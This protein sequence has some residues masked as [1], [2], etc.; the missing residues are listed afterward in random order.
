MSGKHYTILS[1]VR[2]EYSVV[3]L[4]RNKAKNG[5]RN[6]DHSF[7]T[8]PCSEIILRDREFCNL[9][10][11]VVRESDTRETLL[12]KSK[13]CNNTW[14]NTIYTYKLQICICNVEKEL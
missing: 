4:H 7:G 9:S 8:N 13:T 11:V 12:R 10:E 6:A 5:R 3:T 2:E 1:L 14:N